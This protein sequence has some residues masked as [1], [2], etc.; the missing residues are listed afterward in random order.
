MPKS[1]VGRAGEIWGGEHAS[2]YVLKQEGVEGI[3]G[4]EG[5]I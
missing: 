4:T 1:K 3:A 2:A 5:P